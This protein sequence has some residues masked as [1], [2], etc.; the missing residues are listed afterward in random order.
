MSAEPGVKHYEYPGLEAGKFVEAYGPRGRIN[1]LDLIADHIP[2]HASTAMLESIT[3]VTDCI[4]DD[5]LYTRTYNKAIQILGEGTVVLD[6][7]LLQ[8]SKQ[9]VRETTNKLDHEVQRYRNLNMADKTRTSYIDLA[10]HYERQGNYGVA[11]TKYVE[12][13]E[14]ADSPRHIVEIRVRICKAA[15]LGNVWPQVKQHAPS[16]L[17]GNEFRTQIRTGTDKGILMVCLGLYY[18][19]K[20]QYNEAARYF[21]TNPHKNTANYMT[22]IISNETIGL[23]GALCAVVAYNRGEF[24]DHVIFSKFKQNY[25]QSSPKALALVQAYHECRYADV[26]KA[27]KDLEV[28]IHIDL[29]LR[30]Q[31][32]EIISAVRGKAMVQFF[33]PFSAM[34]MERMANAFGVNIKELEKELVICISQGHINAKIDSHNKVVQAVDPDDEADLYD[35]VHQMGS[36]WAR[37]TKAMLLRMSCLQHGVEASEMG[38]RNFDGPED[39]DGMG[40]LGMFMNFGRGRHQ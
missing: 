22:D 8:E 1:R 7:F 29:Y 34:S 6:E 30:D 27:L 4:M 21:V 2:E 33:S 10:E 11:L 28:D 26:T 23:Y 31:A 25:L 19:H 3:N 38:E 36:N 16:V 12:A 20:K 18:L 15:I 17:E 13:F 9:K 32:S 5:D 40:G 35:S 37:E 24:E 14:C 39:G